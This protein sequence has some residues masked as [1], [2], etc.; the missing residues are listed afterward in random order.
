MAAKIIW[1]PTARK[2]FDTLINSLEAKWEK[3]VIENL[4]SDLNTTL[5]LITHNPDMFPL[6]STRK[7]LRKCVLRKKTLL[8]YRVKDNGSI[9][10]VIFA[11]SRQNPKKYKI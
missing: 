2:S 1:S 7:K 6:I 3:K 9:E 8:I 4:F 11:D 5:T 10:L